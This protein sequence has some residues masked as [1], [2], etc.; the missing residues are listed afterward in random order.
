VPIHDREWRQRRRDPV[1]QA[2]AVQ[3]GVLS[4]EQLDAMGITW[5]QR[6]AEIAAGRWER[7]GSQCLQVSPADHTSTWW[8]AI[9]EVGPSAVL[10]GV[11]ALQAAGLKTIASDVV[12]VAVP[13]SV[14]PRPYPGVRV[15][16][17]RRYREDDVIRAG[18][19]RMRPA[20]AAVHA[21][22]WARTD[23]EAALFVVAS[24]QQR[25]VSVRD[26]ADALALI[27]RD[28]RR[29]L[30]RGLLADVRDG[31][32]ALGEQDFARACRRRGFPKPDHQQMRQL[33]TGRVYYDSVW[34]RYGVKVEIHGSQHFDV[35]AA[36]RDALKENAASL[37]G[38][39]LI[40][41]PNHAFRTDPELFLDQ[42]AVA[43]RA[44][45]W[46]PLQRPG[47]TA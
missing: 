31:M 21:A 25:L 15:H 45:G 34:S 26:L 29:S 37:E 39:I 46:Q 42:I 28:R 32:Q 8:R 10:D 4:H 24:V 1:T 23:R 30:L 7:S 13:K 22:L 17:T 40:R 44:G 33:P 9:F 20:T 19:P 2:A 3:G 35:A 5:S 47:L 38:A 41:I 16:E 14:D 6:R 11:T 43:L 12:H 27:K 18:I 36:T